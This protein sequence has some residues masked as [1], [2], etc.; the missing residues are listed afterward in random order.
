MKRSQDKKD[1]RSEDELIEFFQ[2]QQLG[3]DS[4]HAI[5][6]DTRS[7]QNRRYVGL[8]LAASIGLLSVFGLVHQNRLTSQRTD[9]VLQE[10]ALNHKTKWRMDAE[11]VTVAALQKNLQELPFTIKLPE[12]GLLE[13]LDLTGGRYCTIS[14]NLAAHL[15][16]L[17]PETAE[18]YSLF[19]TPLA[20]NLKSMNSSEV[21]VAG[22]DVKL[23]Q[24][25][26]VVY[27]FASHTG[28]INE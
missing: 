4:L 12:S 28:G 1:T 26:D 20:E 8:A 21:E 27:A 19:L 24:E 23:W 18:K 25:Q 5:I 6:D 22:V 9:M 13:Q 16:F 2:A 15:K 10:A 3:S 7:T 17:H 11:G 14:G